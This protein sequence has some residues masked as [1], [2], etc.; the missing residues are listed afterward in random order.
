MG[1]YAA[2][3]QQV[4]EAAQ[5]LTRKGYLMA[6]GGNLSV[7]IAGQQ[8]F[9]ITPSNYDYMKMVAEEVDEVNKTE[10]QPPMVLDIVCPTGSIYGQAPSLPTESWTF[11]TSDVDPGPNYLR[12]E[13]L[14]GIN[15]EIS[16]FHFWGIDAFHNGTAWVEC[17]TDPDSFVITFYEDDAGMPGA[18]VGA[19]DLSISGIPTGQTFGTL[20]FIQKEYIA[21]LSPTVTVYGGWVSVQGSTSGDNCWL[22][23]QNSFTGD[24]A[25]WFFDGTSIV[26]D[27]IDLSMCILGTDLTWLSAN[28]I[29][30]EVAPGANGVINAVMDATN[31]TAG[32]HTGDIYL[33]TN[34]PQGTVNIPVTF[35]V[36]GVGGCS[37][38]PGDI[39]NFGG[40]NGIDVTYGVAYLKGGNPPPIDCNPPCAVAYDPFYAAMDVNATCST[41][42]ID[43]TYFVAYLKGLQP[44]LLYCD[45]CPPARMAAPGTEIPSI[46]PSMRVRTS[47]P[48]KGAE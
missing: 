35:V 48:T 47:T 39:N 5:Q 11:G 16:E 42:G 45:D 22:L 13:S 12:Y 46:K 32:T 2:F 21:M 4:L 14:A 9:A 29:Y 41:N 7:R 17:E 3:K 19:Y 33:A 15:A 26:A 44:S 20:P 43:I 30:L 10:D 31:L 18:V 38:I 24:G 34:A 37:Y 40:A 1:Q 23:W 36:T 8:A 6:T 27:D 28:P 25:S